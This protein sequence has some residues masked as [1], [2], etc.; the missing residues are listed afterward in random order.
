M[1]K[2]FHLDKSCIATFC[3]S[4]PWPSIPSWILR[5][6]RSIHCSITAYEG[7]AITGTG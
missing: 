4:H 1:E 5:K 7:F 3:D 2:N 6:V